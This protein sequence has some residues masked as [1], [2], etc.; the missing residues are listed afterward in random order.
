MFIVLFEKRK[1]KRKHKK[2]IYENVPGVHFF[3]LPK[4]DLFRRGS[5]EPREISTIN[6][7]I[8]IFIVLS[9]LWNFMGVMLKTLYKVCLIIFYMSKR[10]ETLIY[11]MKWQ[12]PFF[13]Y[14]FFSWF[15]LIAF[16]TGDNSIS[17][18]LLPKSRSIS[19]ER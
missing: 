17:K 16:S 18:G 7:S 4:S 11:D 19:K 8:N 2:L 6:S 1:E 12:K 3:R 10:Y 9:L 14:S 5:F 13:F 15:S